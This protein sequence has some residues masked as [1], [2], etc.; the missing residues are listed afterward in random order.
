MGWLA[1]VATKA[2]H[3]SVTSTLQVASIEKLIAHYNSSLSAYRDTDDQ[4]VRALLTDMQIQISDE[5]KKR[6]VVTPMARATEES[7]FISDSA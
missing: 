6:G 2:A 3:K 1:Q 7:P 5:L 4:K